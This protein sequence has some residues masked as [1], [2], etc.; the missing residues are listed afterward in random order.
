MVV[1]MIGLCATAQ[2]PAYNLADEKY[3]AKQLKE[4]KKTALSSRQKCI[5]LL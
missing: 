5:F 1:P 4:K 3:F 2:P